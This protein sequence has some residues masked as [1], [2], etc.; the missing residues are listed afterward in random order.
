MG[1]GGTAAPTAA[2]AER[3]DG[4]AA[5]AG[6]R[7]D[8]NGEQRPDQ[9]AETRRRVQALREFA[10]GTPVVPILCQEEPDPDAIA[11]AF[12]VRALLRRSE[13]EAPLVAL[14]RVQRPETRRMIELL[15]IAVTRVTEAELRAFERVIAVDLEPVVLRGATTRVAVIDHHPP[16]K[17][18][19]TE[20]Y[21]VRPDYGA[22]ATIVTEY[23]RSA[24]TTV[25]ERLATALLYGIRTDTALLTRGTSRAD[26]EAY[27]FL[28]EHADP[29]L[30]ARIDRPAYPRDVVPV[31]GR[32][33]QHARM[34]DEV[35]VVW[36]GRV[37][38]EH[39]HMMPELADLC[40]SIEGVTWAA[41]GGVLDDAL[42]AN[43]RHLGEGSPGAGDVARHATRDAGS[44]GGHPSMA[45]VEMP[46]D[47]APFELEGLDGEKAEDER[48][49][50]VIERVG[51]RML[52][53]LRTQL[54][55]VR[56]GS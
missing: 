54:D 52:D 55:A 30:V 19:V 32:A 28:Q 33:L 6:K 15:D 1:D 11:S 51:D 12:G 7:P 31:F 48:D 22:A 38:R 17:G 56:S 8:Q 21:D 53:W 41:A 29:A 10:A 42:V 46:L 14:G 35:A 5:S 45:R 34:A 20:F 50:D 39:G 25:G 49:S 9:S 43:I 40:L 24:D 3:T 47:Q 26:V 2:D 4:R 44:G 16:E 18:Y 37:A 23:L 36:L 13:K 27:G